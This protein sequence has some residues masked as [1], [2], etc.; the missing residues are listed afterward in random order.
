MYGVAKLSKM[1]GGVEKWAAV[2]SCAFL[3]TWKLE[4]SYCDKEA[5][6]LFS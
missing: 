3:L 2:F 5:I 4:K 1:C 6:C